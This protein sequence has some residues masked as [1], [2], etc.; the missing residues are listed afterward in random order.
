M[1]IEILANKKIENR[2]WYLCKGNLLE[3]LNNLKP[4]FYEFTIQRRIVKNRYLDSLFS[5]IKLGDPIPMITLTYNNR[6]GLEIISNTAEIDMTQVEILDGLQRTFRL[7]AYKILSDE[8]KEC[9]DKTAANFAKYIK[10]KHRQFFDVGVISTSLI[11]NL[12]DSEERDINQISNLFSE[13]D[14]YFFLWVGL[15]DKEII[16][17]MLVLNAGQKAVSNTH[18]FELLF[19][20]WYNYINKQNSLIIL[21]REKDDNSP[22][23]KKG[24]RKIGEFMF[25]SVIVA[26]QSFLEM[27]PLRVSDDLI[28]NNNEEEE[29]NDKIY[30]NVFS[31]AFIEYYLS[32]L[33]SL[34]TILMEIESEKGKEW[35]VK[36]TTLSGVFAAIGKYTNISENWTIDELVNSSKEGFNNLSSTKIQINRQFLSRHSSPSAPLQ[37]NLI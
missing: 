19:L 21:Y 20:H 16:R 26:L 27:K 28:D 4:T 12:I 36:D 15:T 6:Q 5:T 3:Y 34:D 11:R 29:S 32:E 14:V 31:K 8:Y 35:F 10:E 23:V 37:V 17:K 2:S 1:K 18:Q 33:Y 13:F 25:S 24:K 9:N 7:W 22:N 30:E